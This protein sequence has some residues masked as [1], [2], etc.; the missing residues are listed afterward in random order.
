M[1]TNFVSVL[2]ILLVA[3][4]V[5]MGIYFLVERVG[6]LVAVKRWEKTHQSRPNYIPYNHYVRRSYIPSNDH[7]VKCSREW[8]LASLETRMRNIENKLG[9]IDD[10]E[11]EN[12]VDIVKYLREDVNNILSTIKSHDNLIKQ[13]YSDRDEDVNKIADQINRLDDIVSNK[14]E[15]DSD[16]ANKS[17]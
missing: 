9:F 6:G 5:V 4:F 2:G 17:K 10:E 1:L 14:S 16:A 8:T 7:C 12:L 11:D 13:L 15:E 3:A